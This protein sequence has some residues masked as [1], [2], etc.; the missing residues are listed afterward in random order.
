MKA[1][2]VADEECK[3]LWDYYQPGR[4]DGVDL[5]LSCG[6]LKP[7]YLSFLV[8]MCRATLLYVHGNHDGSYARRHPEGC[9]CIE[10]E[11]VQVGSLRILGLGG[12]I[13]YNPGPHQYTEE[14][15]CRRIRKLRRR[16]KKCGGVDVVMSHAPVRG[17]GDAEEGP[18][19]GFEAFRDFA[20]EY[21]PAYWFYGHVHKHYGDA[22]RILTNGHTTFINAFERYIIDLPGEF[23]EPVY[24][25]N[26]HKDPYTD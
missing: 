5:I 16:I 15:M 14:E 18:H 22:H 4:L 21:T 13:R 24:K 8:S 12:S 19:R 10:D 26:R 17:F 3:A 23:S 20:E 7:E 1:L 6:D 11:I 2:L 9:M 25:F